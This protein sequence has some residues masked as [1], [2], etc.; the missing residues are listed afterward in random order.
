MTETL[1]TE[2][3][4]CNL[5]GAQ[6]ASVVYPEVRRIDTVGT[7]VVQCNGCGL[8]YLNPR[9]K[10]LADNFTLNEAYLRQ[11]Y[12]P[13]YQNVGL[14]GPDG[15]L[16]AEKIYQIYQRYLS[17]MRSYRQTNR[18]LDVGCA[19]GL[20]LVATNADGWESYGVDPSEPLSTY[21]REKYG[22]E[23]YHSELSQMAF[24]RR[25]F[26]VVT[27][28]NVIEHLLDP[29]AV[30]R[31]VHRVLRPGGLLI[32]QMPNWDDI[33]REFLGPQWD[34]FVT[35]HFYYFT[36]AT[37]R[38]MLARTGFTLK[39]IESA[40]L[41]ASEVDEIASKRDRA[42]ADQALHR[43]KVMQASDRGSTITALAEKPVTQR[44]RLDKVWQ[45][46]SSGRWQVLG[47]EVWNYI[48]WKL[49]AIA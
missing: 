37:T 8:V 29:M 3:V 33:A 1:P 36:H 19:I 31:E 12:L 39:D 7:Q 27:L 5:C 45:L 18:V 49:A 14:L 28:W 41:C 13:L 40:E 2:F 17:Q 47:Q 25:H 44:D 15:A 42:A 16:E 6:D 43:L 20:F 30:L 34:M 9:L 24:P 35:D 21:G 46:V 48:R 10:R 26:D 32:L 38:Q 23:I 11:F 4:N 22:V